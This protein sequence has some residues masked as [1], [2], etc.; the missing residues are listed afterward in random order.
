MEKILCGWQYYLTV[1]SELISAPFSEPAVVPLIIINL[2]TS[3]FFF[4]S[5]S[6][7]FDHTKKN[8]DTVHF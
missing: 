6:N 3:F 1:G 5:E 7:L 8:Q 2:N 4:I